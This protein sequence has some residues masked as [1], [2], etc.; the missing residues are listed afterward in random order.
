VHSRNIVHRD[1]KKDNILVFK[2]GIPK[3]TD[4]SVSLEVDKP[5]KIL[6]RVGTTKIYQPPEVWEDC[7]YLGFP[8]DIWSLGVV[9]WEMI[10]HTMPFKSTT[11]IALK[12]EILA[13]K[14]VFPQVELDPDLK[15]VLE[16]TLTR[17]PTQRWS[18]EQVTDCAWLNRPSSPT[19]IESLTTS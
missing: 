2:G 15:E 16:G 18:V 17:D 4:Y 14:P 3:I 13:F 19:K 1:I 6:L 7:N 5:I 8:H 12:Q 10:F 11:E 9:L